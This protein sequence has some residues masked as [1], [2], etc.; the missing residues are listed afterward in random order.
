MK[1]SWKMCSI[2]LRTVL[3]GGNDNSLL[4]CFTLYQLDMKSNFHF[5]FHWINVLN[6]THISHFF[7]LSCLLLFLLLWGRFEIGPLIGVSNRNRHTESINKLRKYIFFFGFILEL[8]IFI[9]VECA[10]PM[11]CHFDWKSHSHAHAHTHRHT[12]FWHW[13]KLVCRAIQLTGC[14]HFTFD[15]LSLLSFRFYVCVLKKI[16][17]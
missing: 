6:F 1:L 17:K 2:E 16:P 8:F 14:T 10:V 12:S 11:P 3:Y 7:G 9:V 5:C 15:I 4:L 13:N